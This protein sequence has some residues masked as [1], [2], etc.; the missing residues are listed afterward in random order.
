MDVEPVGNIQPELEFA[1]IFNNYPISK[2]SRET[3]EQIEANVRYGIDFRIVISMLQ[4]GVWRVEFQDEET[5]IQFMETM[6][7]LQPQFVI[8]PFRDLPA[9][10]Y[11]AHIPGRNL[12]DHKILSTIYKDNVGIDTSH[13]HILTIIPEA[14]EMIVEFQVDAESFQFIQEKN[15][16]LNF[17]SSIITFVRIIN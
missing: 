17:N 10:I 1:I 5:K 7:V 14:D 3:K 11:Q 15:E 8:I 6:M 4:T 2:I 13:W 12:T 9:I 16:A